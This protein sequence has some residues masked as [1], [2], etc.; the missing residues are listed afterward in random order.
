M[1]GGSV[2]AVDGA[3]GKLHPVLVGVIAYAARG[4]GG[5]GGGGG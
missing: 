2:P 5:R 1:L 3:V 4:G